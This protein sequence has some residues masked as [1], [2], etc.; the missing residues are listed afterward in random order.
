MLKA[1]I[2]DLDGVL[3]ETEL[4]TFRFYQKRLADLGVH[5]PEDAFRYK[6]GRKSKDFFN[7]ALTEDQRQQVDVAKLLAE[8]RELF[9][10]SI[11][12][13]AKKVPGGQELIK[14]LSGQGLTLALASQNEP[15][16]INS[17]LDWLGVRG[18]FE[19]ILSLEDI[20]NK[21]PDPEIYERARTLLGCALKECVVIEDSRDGVL[22]AQNAGIF[23]IQLSHP[24]M[25]KEIA[26]LGDLTV[27][28][29]DEVCAAIARYGKQ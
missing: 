11:S 22:A 3:I 21:K 12:Q 25:P 18:Y 9:N 7:D 13:Y 15:R 2:F 10:I 16:M 14:W 24:Y 27:N 26:S 19:I 28:S 20:K 17:S 6:A 5:L 23:C 8:K 1:V 4:E 29:L